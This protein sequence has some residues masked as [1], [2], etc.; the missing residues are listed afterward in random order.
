MPS[1]PDPA[2]VRSWQL[3]ELRQL[4]TGAVAAPN[5]PRREFIPADGPAE[6]VP[7][8]VGGAA[9]IPEALLA[10]AR[11]AAQAAGYL[12]GWSHGVQDAQ[13]RAAAEQEDRAAALRLADEQRAAL[14]QRA[15][16]A[17]DQAADQLDE[18]ATPGA[19]EVEGLIIATALQIAEALVGHSLRNDDQRAE[20]A[21]ARVLDLAPHTEPVVVRLSPADH[22]LLTE[23][24]ELP[25][26]RDRSITLVADPALSP[27]DAVATSGATEIDARIAAGLQRVREVLGR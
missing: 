23:C 25:G 3:L 2:T 8:Q 14:F 12:A 13:Q 27:G 5:E 7:F 22:A 21:L 18:R 1:S 19:A 4:D 9:G 17:V 6:L 20:A 10:P 16:A 24:D 11:A 26:A 15:I